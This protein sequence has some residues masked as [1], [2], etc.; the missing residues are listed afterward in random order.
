VKQLTFDDCTPDRPAPEPPARQRPA[1]TRYLP[2]LHNDFW[3]QRLP[4]GRCR[5]VTIP[6]CGEYL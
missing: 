3:G 6:I 1:G 5:I 2:R 4:V